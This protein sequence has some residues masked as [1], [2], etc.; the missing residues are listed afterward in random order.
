MIKS[1]ITRITRI[2]IKTRITIISVT[3]TMA[4]LTRTTKNTRRAIKIIVQRKRSD[5]KQ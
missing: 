3:T 2:P 1:I 4:R 5:A